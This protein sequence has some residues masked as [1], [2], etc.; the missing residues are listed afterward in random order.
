[1]RTLILISLVTL[2]LFLAQSVPNTAQAAEERQYKNI[3]SGIVRD[4]KAVMGFEDPDEIPEDLEKKVEENLV[5]HA[6]RLQ[7]FV[8]SNPQSQWADDAWFLLSVLRAGDPHQEAE[9]LE[10]LL[11]L[12]TQVNL[13]EWTKT[14]LPWCTPNNPALSVRMQLLM[15]YAATGQDRKLQK[16]YA[17]A[18][19]RFPEKKH[20]LQRILAGSR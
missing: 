12:H 2:L 17:E 20:L 11:E 15:H 4:F 1:M 7:S 18:V 8:E 9:V 13:E 3:A 10:S 14:T 16:L 6:R 19:N 5:L